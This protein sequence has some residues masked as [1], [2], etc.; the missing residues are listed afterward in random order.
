[1]KSRPVMK[2]VRLLEDR[3]WNDNDNDMNSDNNNIH[4]SSNIN[5]NNNNNSNDNSNSAKREFEYRIP[6]LHY[7]V[8][9]RRFPETFADFCENKC[10]NLEQFRH[11]LNGYLAQRVPSLLL[12]SSFRTCSNGEV[13]KGMFPWR[14]GYPLSKVRP[15]SLLTLWISEGLTQA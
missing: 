2:V 8:N 4:H 5:T 9:P 1:M 11:R 12:A 10:E 15:I 3:R 14:T 13:L 6:R 7:P